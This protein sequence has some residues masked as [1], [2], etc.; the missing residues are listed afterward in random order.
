MDTFFIH[1]KYYSLYRSRL[2]THA[3]YVHISYLVQADNPCI[4][5]PRIEYS[6]V[7]CANKSLADAVSKISISIVFVRVCAP[8][9]YYRAYRSQ[10]NA[11]FT[12]SP[13]ELSSK[14]ERKFKRNLNTGPQ[15]RIDSAG[16]C[17]NLLLA[18]QFVF[19]FCSKILLK[20]IT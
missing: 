6:I 19:I 2:F 5:V 10:T 8:V 18:S 20:C 11:E 16:I 3:L 7:S 12:H 15:L 1:L 13:P 4:A 14:F 9:H 17:L